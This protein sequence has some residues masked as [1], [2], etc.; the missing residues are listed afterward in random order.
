MKKGR[1]P[2]G[3][4]NRLNIDQGILFFNIDLLNT[5]EKRRYKQSVA[6]NTK[7]DDISYDENVNM[8]G[9]QYMPTYS[10][11]L[12]LEFENCYSVMGSMDEKINKGDRTPDKQSDYV[13]NSGPITRRKENLMQIN[14]RHSDQSDSDLGRLKNFDEF[15]KDVRNVENEM[16]M[17]RPPRVNMDRYQLNIIQLD[18]NSEIN[19]QNYINKLYEFS[20]KISKE[21]LNYYM[22]FV[23]FYKTSFQQEY[24]FGNVFTKGAHNFE[25]NALNLLKESNYDINLALRKI[26]YPTVSLFEESFAQGSSSTKKNLQDPMIYVNSALNDLIGSN[27]QEKEQWMEY[28][29][30][31]LNN[32][33]DFQEIQGLVDLA[34]KMKIDVPEFVL[35]EIENCLNFA[36]NIRRHLNE[37]NTIEDIIKLLEESTKYKIKTEEISILE[38]IIK[39]A[40]SWILRVNELED[41]TINYK[42]LQTLFNEAKNMPIYLNK[43][44]SIKARYL[45]A[46]KWQE[47]YQQLP[48]HSKT[49]QQNG[50]NKVERCTIAYLYY[51]LKE[52][53]EINFSSNETVSLISNYEK[54][55]ETEA[56]I[57]MTLED[58]DI[59]S[60]KSKDLLNEFVNILDSLKFTTDLYDVVVSKLEYFD[61][62]EKENIT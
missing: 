55:R 17:Y 41:K 1:K 45:K 47:K 6:I 20:E 53:E 52:C 48:K 58:S 62:E 5:L 13:P 32:G 2:K 29:K 50:T 49:R 56:R 57:Q 61:W 54:L 22:K 25:E 10:T 12:N 23:S 28:V 33:V 18:V 31:R 44:D 46:Q 24:G 19:Y 8:G 34:N 38:D 30:D 42:T 39:K 35:K 21:D 37:K 43:L 9:M 59:I 51:L 16:Y 7:S 3:K 14:G 36:R 11:N 27:I 4:H 26:L 15:Y 60:P 40:N